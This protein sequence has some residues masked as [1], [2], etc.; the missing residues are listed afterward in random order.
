MSANEQLL[1]AL[2]T[3]TVLAGQEGLPSILGYPHCIDA[4][5]QHRMYGLIR[6]LVEGGAEGRWLT[7]GDSGADAAALVKAGIPPGQVIASSL[8]AAQLKRLEER[9]LL[10]GIEI[11]EVNAEAIPLATDGID[12]VL[13]KEVY[14]HLPRPALGLYEMLRVARQAVVLI[15]PLDFLGRPLDRLRDLVKSLM[16]RKYVQGEFECYGNYTY[17]LSLRET[18]KIMTAMSYPDMYV[19]RFNDFGNNA[20]GEPTSNVYQMSLHRLAFAT[21]D[22]LASLSLMS[23]GKAAVVL[24]KRPLPERIAGPLAAAGFRRCVLPKNP[25]FTAASAAP[26]P[27]PG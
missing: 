13:A 22:L 21:Q 19:R 14:H 18:R 27:L 16:R 5:R 25:Y 23:W 17:R 4:W 26:H 12:F 6:P 9:G 8:C 3:K 1:Y 20:S 11:R 7:I 2:Q 15:E 24:S 10:P